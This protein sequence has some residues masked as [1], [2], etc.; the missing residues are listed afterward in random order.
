MKE[1]KQ[2]IIMP[3]GGRL[4]L[5]LDFEVTPR[6]V[7]KALNFEGNSDLAERLRKAAL[8]RGGQLYEAVS[9]SGQ[10]RSIN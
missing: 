9:V 4:R 1:A 7:Y 10:T 6:M 5:A 2:R 3:L 8:E